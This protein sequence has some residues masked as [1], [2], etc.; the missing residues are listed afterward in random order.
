MGKAEKTAGPGAGARRER[1]LERLAG[2]TMLDD[3]FMRAVMRDNMP[4]AQRVLR[5]VTGLRG[6]ALASE[7]TQRD[8]KRVGGSR[9][10]ALD[11]YCVDEGGAQYDMEVQAGSDL[12]PRRFRYY[13][14][15]MDV[16]FL[17]SGRGW[18]ELP[19]RWA[20]VVLESDPAGPA[21]ARR[22]YRYVDEEGGGSYGDGT[23]VLYANAAYRGDDELGRL[24]ADFCEPDPDRIRDPLLRERVQYLKRDPEGVREMGRISEEIY[25][26]G[27]ADGIEQGIEQGV[28]RG[29]QQKLLDNVRSMVRNLS[30]SAWQAMDALD[31]PKS[32]QQRYIAML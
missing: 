1:G 17:E 10:C 29:S 15:S 32:D 21:R 27:L 9:S 7:E 12:D 26:E 25:N 30:M 18:S 23:R 4:L 13:G 14:S 22:A 8:L 20:V 2:Y 31:V 24:M 5:T 11:V 3:A 28:E 16:D 19:E 6:L